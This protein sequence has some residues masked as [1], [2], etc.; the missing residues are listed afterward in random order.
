[1]A[2]SMLPGTLKLKT[3][4]GRRASR[5]L[6][7]ASRSITRKLSRTTLSY[8]NFSYSAAC[9]LTSDGELDAGLDDALGLA[10]DVEGLLDGDAAGL[11]GVAEALAAELE[12]YPLV[13]WRQRITAGLLVHRLGLS[14]R[15]YRERISSGL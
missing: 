3:R 7:I 11:A 6:L 13:A 5:Q 9:G 2:R 4:I 15:R 8:V 10:G 1:M 14:W 12:D